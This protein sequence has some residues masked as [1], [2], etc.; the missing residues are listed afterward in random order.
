MCDQ[1][2]VI[3]GLC[4]T[5][6]KDNNCQLDTSKVN[7]PVRYTAGG[8]SQPEYLNKYC[9]ITDDRCA[10]YMD[11]RTK[12]I[13][14]DGTKSTG[15]V[16]A[17]NTNTNTN[18]NNNNNQNKNKLQQQIPANNQQ[19]QQKTQQPAT[20]Q[21]TSTQPKTNQQTT[22]Q[23]NKQTQ[24]V[25]NK[26]TANN[27]KAVG[28]AQN[29]VQN[30]A[31]QAQN[32][33]NPSVI[34]NTNTVSNAVANAGTNTG[35]TAVIGNS[36]DES[37]NIDDVSES[38]KSS[39][40]SNNQ[41]ASDNLVVGED[42]NLIDNSARVNDNV[43]QVGNGSNNN[44][45]GVSPVVIGSLSFLFVVVALV[46]FIFI[47][48]RKNTEESE[49]LDPIYRNSNFIATPIIEKKNSQI[50][51]KSN[52]SY[53]N[54]TAI[55][56]NNDG[57]FDIIISPTKAVVADHNTA[58]S[59]RG[60][61]PINAYAEVNAVT[62][63]DSI[64]DENSSSILQR[65]EINVSATENFISESNL[66]GLTTTCMNTTSLIA[67]TGLQTNID[68]TNAVVPTTIGSDVNSN[69]IQPLVPAAINQNITVQN[70]SFSYDINDLSTHDPSVSFINNTNGISFING[71]D[72][73]YMISP[74]MDKSTSNII[75]ADMVGDNSFSGDIK[76]ILPTQHSI[77]G[78][79]TLSMVISEYKENTIY[80]AKFNYEP[81]MDD[82]MKIRINDR[83]LVKEIFNDG[84]AYGE[85]KTSESLGIFPIN[86]LDSSS[87]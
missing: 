4:T 73:S 27:N 51:Q 81:S 49:D 52:T 35:G 33:A 59:P 57:D 64:F 18:T 21:K 32:N 1:A 29:G 26:N 23:A 42:G 67:P 43:K 86:R 3:F 16:P 79:K 12:Q 36:N 15:K 83:V 74:I 37:I 54:R 77:R 2:K 60:S 48:K 70:A 47:K 38:S 13:K 87:Y 22:Q 72:E 39:S 14:K 45:N 28:S 80:N 10:W 71:K 65:S 53:A 55:S 75:T 85:N 63:N 46:G 84:W 34:G 44:N 62:G 82:E 17:R 20:Q 50:S 31:A 9:I 6:C 5:Y 78:K 11:E 58:T 25:A 56:S 24:P 68:S 69:I 66:N 40:S 8:P 7:Y 19:T 61:G 76:Q 30:G 41:K